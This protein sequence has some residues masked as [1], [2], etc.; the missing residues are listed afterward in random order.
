TFSTNCKNKNAFPKRVILV[1]YFKKATLDA[2]KVLTR[3]QVLKA[4]PIE[5]K[6]SVNEKYANLYICKKLTNGDTIYVFEECE[7]PAKFALDTNVDHVVVI[8][9]RDTPMHYPDKIAE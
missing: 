9:K 1:K 6:C 4:Y 5:M 7:E 3:I 8:N 2:G